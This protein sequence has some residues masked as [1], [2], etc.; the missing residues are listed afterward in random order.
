MGDRELDYDEYFFQKSRYKVYK[1]LGDSYF[2]VYIYSLC[3]LYVYK[4]TT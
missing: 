4:C 2:F 3:D 1:M